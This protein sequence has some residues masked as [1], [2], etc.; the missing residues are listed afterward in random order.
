MQIHPQLNSLFDCLKRK[1]RDFLIKKL[2]LLMRILLICSN[3]NFHFSLP[4]KS[5]VNKRDKIIF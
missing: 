4:D 1:E 5:C 2:G 3:K